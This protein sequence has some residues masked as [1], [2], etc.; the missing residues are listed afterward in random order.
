M[1]NVIASMPWLVKL[2]NNTLEEVNI[3][4]KRVTEKISVE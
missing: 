2:I 3:K 1:Q 4:S